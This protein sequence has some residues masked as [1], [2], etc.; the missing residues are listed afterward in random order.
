MNHHLNTE[1]IITISNALGKLKDK[2]VFVGGATLSFY[3][4][5]PVT[6]V[7]PTKDIDLIVEIIAYKGRIEIEEELRRLGF[8]H[9]TESNIT[10]RYKFGEITVDVIPTQDP[11]IGF[12]NRWYRDGFLSA[13]E[14][15]S[16]PGNTFKILTPPF[17]I[18]TKL[19]AFLSRG[20][21]MGR[22]SHDFED[23]VFLLENRTTIWD[24]MAV[25]EGELFDYLKEKFGQLS[26]HPQI[27]EWVDGHVERRIPPMT[28]FVVESM[29]R[30][31][32]DNHKKI[33][34]AV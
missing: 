26:R 16:V 18:A 32:N 6:D 24:E 20:K 2:V 12:S 27:E 28:G 7:R 11:S 3:N 9:D 30:F 13:Q 19:E 1:R 31:A 17:F 14:I 10:C 4:D 21:G 22:T 33:R 15:D 23:I 8:A 5:L 29:R 25:T 34:Q